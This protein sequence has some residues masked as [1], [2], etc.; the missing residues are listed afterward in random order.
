[1]SKKNHTDELP[2]PD[3]DDDLL[4]TLDKNLRDWYDDHKGHKFIS[5][6]NFKNLYPQWDKYVNVS[7]GKKFYK[8]KRILLEGEC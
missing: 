6:T 4:N 8:L 3:D 1:M 5:P 2:F 7:F